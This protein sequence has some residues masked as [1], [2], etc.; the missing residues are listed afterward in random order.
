MVIDTLIGRVHITLKL[1][2]S[3]TFVST[4]EQRLSNF[5]YLF[6]LYYARKSLSSNFAICTY[7]IIA[8]LKVFT[9]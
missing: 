5:I 4:F 6:I 2:V 1:P 7:I 9:I 8:Q 3:Y